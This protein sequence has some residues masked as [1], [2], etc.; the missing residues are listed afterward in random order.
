MKGRPGPL[1]GSWRQGLAGRL[2]PE[3]RPLASIH[4]IGRPG[5]DIVSI[6]GT[7][8]SIDEGVD[9]LLSAS[10]KHVR[11]EID[12]LLWYH[13]TVEWPWTQLDSEA[14]LRQ[15]LGAAIAAFHA[16][17]VEPY[18]TQIRHSLRAERAAQIER[19]AGAGID[20][21]LAGI[22]PPMI[23]WHPPVLHVR[24]A[25]GPERD[26]SLRGSGLIFAA[27]AFLSPYPVLFTDLVNR[28]GPPT[29][30]Y[31]AVRDLGQAF[32][33]WNIQEERQALAG[34]L[35]RTR[36]SVLDA[37]AGG[38]STGVLAQ[39]VGISPAAASQHLAVLRRA[40]LITTHR[41]GRS[42]AH[43]LTA[44]GSALLTGGPP[45]PPVSA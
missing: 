17:A 13:P 19:L 5:L 7:A 3:L 41:S 8:D 31:P 29:L 44:L 28:D 25:P 16:E 36:C 30:V 9:G 24:N 23:Q 10:R 12:W 18:W 33:L 42:V 11:A 34:L 20:T 39:R 22:C 6:V 2:G 21:F 27:S 38:S 15:Q 45:V 40:G 35:G 43:S 37:V 26:V 32:E 4:P 14:E 1:Y